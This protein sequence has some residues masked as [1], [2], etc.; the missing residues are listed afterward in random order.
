MDKHNNFINQMKHCT[1][2]K[3]DK[4]VKEFVKRKS[5]KDGLG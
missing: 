2:C 4:S 1:K 3:T 5:A